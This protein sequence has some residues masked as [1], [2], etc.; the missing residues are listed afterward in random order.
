[1]NTQETT[2]NVNSVEAHRM[3]EGVPTL[4]MVNTD[5]ET[6]TTNADGVVILDLVSDVHNLRTESMRNRKKLLGIY[7]HDNV[8]IWKVVWGNVWYDLCKQCDER[9]LESVRH[10]NGNLD[11][12]IKKT[13]GRIRN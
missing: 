11:D 5:T 10:I 13:L 8:N 7:T 4:P 3:E 6:E 9:V 1:M 2:D 12:N